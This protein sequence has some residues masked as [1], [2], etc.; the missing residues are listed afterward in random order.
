MTTYG[1]YV[2]SREQFLQLQAKGQFAAALS[3]ERYVELQRRRAHW[4]QEEFNRLS[5]SDRAALGRLKR[6]SKKPPIK[7]AA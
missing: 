2:L 5:A 3:Y 4:A 6:T 1:M 7:R